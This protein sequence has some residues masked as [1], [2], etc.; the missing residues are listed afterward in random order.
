MIVTKFEISVCQELNVKMNIIYHQFIRYPFFP[1]QNDGHAGILSLNSNL[2][3][4]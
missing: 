2:K 1:T 3:P 4:M